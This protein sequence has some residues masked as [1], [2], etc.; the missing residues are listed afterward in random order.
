MISDKLGINGACRQGREIARATVVV[1]LFAIILQGC[2]GAG[3]PDSPPSA[4][5]R[6]VPATK[7]LIHTARESLP[8]PISCEMWVVGAEQLNQQM[9]VDVIER[10]A[11]GKGLPA[12]F[13][14]SGTVPENF[15]RP[16]QG[17]WTFPNSQ[18]HFYD[19]DDNAIRQQRVPPNDRKT[20]LAIV[21]RTPPADRFYVKWMYARD[22]LIVFSMKPTNTG[23]W[24]A[25][26]APYVVLNKDEI[27]KPD[28]GEVGPPPPGTS[29]R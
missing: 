17:V 23:I 19:A 13:Y 12:K 11:E 7:T 14:T 27:V 24:V 8:R 10:I 25:G 4:G 28:G 18:Q 22:G 9:P 15:C 3:K 5:A 29:V 16:V 1:W 26:G 6:V 21:H 2:V 20:I